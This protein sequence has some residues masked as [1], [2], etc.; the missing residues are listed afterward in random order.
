MNFQKQAH[1]FNK[2]PLKTM[3][4]RNQKVGSSKFIG[5]LVHPFE[6]CASRGGH[7]WY[8]NTK[9]WYEKHKHIQQ[10]KWEDLHL[11]ASI[12]NPWQQHI[13]IFFRMDGNALMSKL[14]GDF[15]Q[16]KNRD[17]AK[18]F[19]KQNK[20]IKNLIISSFREKVSR[21]YSF[22][23]NEKN[24]E[25]DILNGKVPHKSAF[26][27]CY[28]NWPIYTLN[29]EIMTSLCIKSDGANIKEDIQ[30]YLKL[31][32]LDENCKHVQK[33]ANEYIRCATQAAINQK[34]H[35]QFY[36]KETRE[37][38]GEMRAMEINAHKYKF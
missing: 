22:Y 27:T 10:T 35:K 24:I 6:G 33:Q 30:T 7:H 26:V 28:I 31:S 37:K 8:L 25:E 14:D 2:E 29:N 15:V 9:E 34:D 11:I 12:R 20:K 23:K 13:S 5:R 36:D 19:N 32:G 17:L 4:L 38:V 18:Q 16:S 1:K 3:Y 21:Q